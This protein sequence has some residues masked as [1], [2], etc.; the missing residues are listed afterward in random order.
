MDG[1]GGGHGAGE[2]VFL[3][4]GSVNRPSCVFFFSPTVLPETAGPTLHCCNYKEGLWQI[5]EIPFK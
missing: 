5:N 4:Q 2:V 1:S 3:L